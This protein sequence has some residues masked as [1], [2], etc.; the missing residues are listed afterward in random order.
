MERKSIIISI[1]VIALV[2]GFI[3][4][5]FYF[6]GSFSLPFLGG[7]ITVP[8]NVT[9]TTTFNGTIRTY[10]PVLQI[11]ANV[12]QSVIGALHNMSGVKDVQVQANDI[13]IDTETRDDVYP[14]AVALGQMNV[15][16][17]L[18]V[19][20][21]KKK[22]ARAE[23]TGEQ[24]RQCPRQFRDAKAVEYQSWLDNQ[25]FELVDLGRRPP[26]FRYRTLGPHSQKGPR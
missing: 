19:A 18:A 15:S 14:I 25:V 22:A 5:L 11:P 6:G 16:D 3:T 21:R 13:L 17:V 20:S 23:A 4:E 8:Q 9:G 1:L 7:G 26:Q 10:D 2:L 24:M 12:S